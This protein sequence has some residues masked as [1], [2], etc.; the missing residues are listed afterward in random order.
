MVEMIV[1]EVG[2][3]MGG[4]E[5][6]WLGEEV[7][8]GWEMWVCVVEVVERWGGVGKGPNLGSDW[9]AD[10]VSWVVVVVF[11]VGGVV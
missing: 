8:C 2:G 6:V 9:V 4:V 1:G 11:D 3:D 10:T 7:W 5:E